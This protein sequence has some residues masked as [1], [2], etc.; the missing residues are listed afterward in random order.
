MLLASACNEAS[1]SPTCFDIGGTYL[2]LDCMICIPR[3][4]HQLL[5]AVR[6]AEEETARRERALQEARDAQN[7]LDDELS[8][9]RCSCCHSAYHICCLLHFR[10]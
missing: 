1:D 8:K 6:A 4:Q 9:A 2:G 7:K 10:H 5:T 3:C